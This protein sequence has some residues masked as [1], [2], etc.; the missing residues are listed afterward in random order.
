MTARTSS[1]GL[2]PNSE[3]EKHIK[4][5]LGCLNRREAHAVTSPAVFITASTVEELW[6]TLLATLDLMNYV[7]EKLGFKY[8]MTSRLSEDG[9]EKL[10]GVIRQFSG[11]NDHPTATQFLLTVNCLGFYD[12]DK[13]SSCGNCEGGNLTFLLG[14]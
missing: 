14:T 3:H 13:A 7:H 1:E 9:L 12:L 11:C 2:K 5:V 4:Y 8:L 6:V 10:F